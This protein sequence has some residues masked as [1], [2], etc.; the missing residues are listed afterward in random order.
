MNVIHIAVRELRALLGTTMGWLVITGF[1]FI[2]G[3]FWA[4][5]LT[6]YALSSM[7]QASTP[8]MSSQMNFR[9]YLLNPFFGN[10]TVVLLLLVPALSMRLFAPELK[11]RTME[12]LFTSPVSTLEIVL[13]KYLGAM[14][15]VAV[16]FL[17]TAH[18]PISLFLLGDPDPWA[19]LGG[20]LEIYLVSGAILSIGMML[21]ALTKSQIV[22]LSTT[23]MV[24]LALLILSWITDSMEYDVAAAEGL[25]GRI[26]Q[27]AKG[28]FKEIALLPHTKGFLEGAWRASDLAYFGF[29]ISF[30][31]FATHQR[32]ESYRWS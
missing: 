28:F 1:L 25:F 14:L 9:D 23:V 3:L 16:M 17:L 15:F 26:F 31:V 22:A 8:F 30:F 29:F 2:T 5:P 6:E 10:T 7:D 21:S 32:V 18:Y 12:L 20:Y 4:I 13:G 27:L 24:G 11:D 19:I